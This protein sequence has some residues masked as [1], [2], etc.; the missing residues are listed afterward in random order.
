MAFHGAIAPR[1]GKAANPVSLNAARE[2][3]Q[4]RQ[5][6][7]AHIV[8]PSIKALESTGTNQLRKALIGM[9]C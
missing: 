1:Q 8:E 3:A 7:L 4:L 2:G 6:G 9:R 5:R